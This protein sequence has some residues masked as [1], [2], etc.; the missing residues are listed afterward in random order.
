MIKSTVSKTTTMKAAVIRE[1]GGPEV[2]HIEEIEKPQTRAGHVLVKVLAAGINRLDHYVRGGG[3]IPEIDTFRI[4][5][6]DAA[7]EIAE[8]GEGVD[9]FEVG[10]RVIVVAGFATER[11]D[12]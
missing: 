2:I 6:A 11:K 5:G 12:K 8:L 10:E 1:F 9:G 7:G 4:L 3:Y